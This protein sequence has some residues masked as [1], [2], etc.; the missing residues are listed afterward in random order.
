MIIHEIRIKNFK[1]IGSNPENPKDYGLILKCNPR[2]NAFI[3]KNGSGKSAV[4]E[5]LELVFKELDTFLHFNMEEFEFK[6]EKSKWMKY[7]DDENS[8]CRYLENEEIEHYYKIKNRD[9]F[10]VGQPEIFIRLAYENTIKFEYIKECLNDKTFLRIKFTFN[11]SA[12][13]VKKFFKSKLLT[14]NVYFLHLNARNRIREDIKKYSLLIKEKYKRIYKEEFATEKMR[15]FESFSD[16]QKSIELVKTLIE[17]RKSIGLS[18]AFLIDEPELYLHP[19]AKK[20]LYKKLKDL[21]EKG[22]QI[23]YIT[24]SAEFLS[25]EEPE[26]IYLFHRDE[27]KNEETGEVKLEDT[28]VFPSYEEQCHRITNPNKK[29]DSH[30]DYLSGES[31]S[32][33]SAFFADFVIIV[34]GKDDKQVIYNI[35]KAKTEKY[36]EYFGISIIDSGSV[37]GTNKVS[38]LYKTFCKKIFCMMDYDIEKNKDLHKKYVKK[39]LK[40]LNINIASNELD[41]IFDTEKDYK[42]KYKAFYKKDEVGNINSILFVFEDKIEI[43]F[44]YQDTKDF[45]KDIHDIYA[46]DKKGCEIVWKEL[47]KIIPTLKQKVSSN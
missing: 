39:N 4:F 33:N 31:L 25:F 16:G 38:L 36:P 28:K 30:I 47:V 37:S 46:K 43:F 26:K 8:I 34:E 41:T 44:G 7:N 10:Y 5:A 1:S 35:I 27:I 22:V 42:N 40:N 13:E 18:L 29:D 14:S 20:S 9:M 24:H 15:Y 45:D 3:G 19:Q 23:F 12:D 21:S 6:N 11:K 32:L 17:N 2:M